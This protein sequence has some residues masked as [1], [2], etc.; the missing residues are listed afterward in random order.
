MQCFLSLLVLLSNASSLDA[1]N[2]NPPI[3]PMSRN[4][5]STSEEVDEDTSNKTQ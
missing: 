1:S 4:D 3:N 5:L 2:N